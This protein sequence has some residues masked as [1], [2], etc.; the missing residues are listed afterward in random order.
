MTKGAILYAR[1]SGDDRANG[2]SSIDAQLDECRKYATQRGYTVVDEVF[3]DPKKHTSGADWLPELDKL[4]RLAPTSTYDVLICH[5]VDRLARNRF[6]QLATEIELENHGILVEY[7]VGQFENTDEG[8][9][10]KGLVS[11]FAEYERGKIRRR[12]TGGK[13][14]YRPLVLSKDALHQASGNGQGAKHPPPT[15]RMARS[16]R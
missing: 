6:K 2:T 13:I 16:W 1:V 11:E 3:E 12:T 10:L 8:R 7:V 9:L 5:E 15:R 14:R 4:I